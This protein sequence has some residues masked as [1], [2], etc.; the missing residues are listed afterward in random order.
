M[1]GI[2]VKEFVVPISIDVAINRWLEDNPDVG[3]VDVKYQVS[4]SKVRALVLFTKKDKDYRRVIKE[5]EMV[6]MP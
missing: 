1:K 2:R 6:V 5:S 4:D 3:V